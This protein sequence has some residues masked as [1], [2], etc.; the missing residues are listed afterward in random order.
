MDIC[1]PGAVRSG[2]WENSNLPLETGNLNA[3]TPAMRWKK[4]TI[5]GVGLLGGSL[6]LAIRRRRL[7]NTVV[8][9]VRRAASVSECRR[10]RAVDVATRDL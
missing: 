7:A 3:E 5:V 6:G 4:I 1:N 9:F 10:L 2:A 8:G